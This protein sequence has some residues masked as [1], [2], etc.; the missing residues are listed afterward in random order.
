MSHKTGTPRRKRR[1]REEVE[2]IKAAFIDVVQEYG[3]LSNR[4][5]YYV[6]VGKGI[7][8]KTSY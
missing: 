6:L 7:I 3:P 8:P 2:R 1:T 4:Q 5:A